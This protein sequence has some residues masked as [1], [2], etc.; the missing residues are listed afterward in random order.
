M[1]EIG[2]WERADE[3]ARTHSDHYPLMLEMHSPVHERRASRGQRLKRTWAPQ[4]IR[5]F[6]GQI[7]AAFRQDPPQDMEEI[8]L[9]LTHAALQHA[10][11]TPRQMARDTECSILRAIHETTDERLRRQCREDLR[12]HRQGL[13]RAKEEQQMA[14]LLLH[15]GGRVKPEIVKS[16]ENRGGLRKAF[17]KTV[18]MRAHEDFWSEVYAVP[19]QHHEE[20]AQWQS[21]FDTYVLQ[22]AEFACEDLFAPYTTVEALRQEISQM[23]DSAAG[24]DGMPRALL[25]ALS[26]EALE[27]IGQMFQDILMRRRSYPREWKQVAVRLIPKVPSPH[28]AAQFRPI[29]VGVVLERLF[30]R[31]TLQLLRATSDM[32]WTLHQYARPGQQGPMGIATMRLQANRCDLQASPH[33]AL[34]TDIA[35]AFDTVLW[36]HIHAALLHQGVPLDLVV[37]LLQPHVHRQLQLHT[38]GD[39]RG[40]VLTCRGLAQGGPTSSELFDRTLDYL[41]APTLHAWNMERDALPL[42]HVAFRD[43]IIILETSRRRLQRKTQQLRD[44]LWR[45]GM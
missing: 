26:K 41:L 40:S 31:V 33:Q 34:K 23:R 20:A 44:A 7:N 21:W 17:T 35:K 36:H 18:T 27:L 25:K 8:T 2:P 13:Q 6:R 16:A 32:M 1:R 30:G 12:K 42:T 45:G 14:Q 10:Q 29:S 11:P 28:F 24:S 5:S 38:H 43:D 9:R 37:A 4:C 15:G 19:E 3:G 39:Q 22:P